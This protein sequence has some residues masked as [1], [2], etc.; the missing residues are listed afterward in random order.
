MTIY[1]ATKSKFATRF[2]LSEVKTGGLS[3]VAGQDSGMISTRMFSTNSGSTPM[4]RMFE[5]DPDLAAMSDKE[6]VAAAKSLYG[7]WAGREDIGDNWLEEM[8]AEDASEWDKRLAEIY[9]PDFPKLPV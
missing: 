6:L 2:A 4:S 3:Y 7:A 8:R 1:T 9:G 5:E